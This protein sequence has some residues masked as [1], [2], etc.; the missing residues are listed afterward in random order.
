MQLHV[1]SAFVVLGP[2]LDRSGRIELHVRLSDQSD[3]AA[4]FAYAVPQLQYK[5]SVR[6]TVIVET[7]SYNSLVPGW[8]LPG[9]A[10]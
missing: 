6:R 8:V 5:I 1:K 4:L 3:F 2:E 10:I 9:E 7:N